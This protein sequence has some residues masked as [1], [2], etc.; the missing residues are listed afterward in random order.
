VSG[1]IL[2]TAVADHVNA[3][4]EN[5]IFAKVGVE[6]TG[7]LTNTTFSINWD[8]NDLMNGT[9]GPG[10]AAF[11]DNKLGQLVLQVKVSF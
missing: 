10:T 6:V 3:Q 11:G 5:D 8:S 4:G 1:K 9:N 7:L 2:G